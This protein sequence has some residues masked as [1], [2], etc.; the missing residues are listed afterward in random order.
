M[1]PFHQRVPKERRAGPT[2]EGETKDGLTEGET[3]DDISYRDEEW[4]E[5]RLEEILGPDWH[6]TDPMEIM[7]QYYLLGKDE[8]EACI[9]QEG[10]YRMNA[11]CCLGPSEEIT[12][13]TLGQRLVRRQS[14]VL[15]NYFNCD[16][17]MR[18]RPFCGDPAKKVC[19]STVDYELG[20][21]P[22]ELWKWGYK[23]LDCI[24]LLDTT[25]ITLKTG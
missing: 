14:V 4:L 8:E 1:L 11:L 25:T 7:R 2:K 6:T 22:Q 18:G 20:S 17:C 10:I 23:G 19:C 5:K 16:L 3:N 15:T 13:P 21:G 24:D 12:V 9:N